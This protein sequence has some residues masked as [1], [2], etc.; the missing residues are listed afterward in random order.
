[1]NRQK[2]LNQCVPAAF[3]STSGS[4]GSIS[5]ENGSTVLQSSYSMSHR[6][7][8]LSSPRRVVFRGQSPTQHCEA[9]PAEKWPDLWSGSPTLTI[10]IYNSSLFL[11]CHKNMSHR[12]K[13]S[14]P[15]VSVLW[16]QKDQ[17]TRCSLIQMIRGDSRLHI[18]P[19][20]RKFW[21]FLFMLFTTAGNSPN[22]VLLSQD[23]DRRWHN[24]EHFWWV[25]VEIRGFINADLW[26]GTR[27]W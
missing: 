19:C 16:K 22:I 13:A 14:C 6:V 17:S 23:Q 1:M 15:V 21:S 4:P 12:G 18:L 8:A 10:L 11:A 26:Y 5:R 9:A 20:S 2:C 24:F 7:Q 25:N 3:K 27:L